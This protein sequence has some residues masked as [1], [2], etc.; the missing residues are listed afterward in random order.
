MTLC[1]D[2]TRFLP[3]RG[4]RGSS[5]QP[6]AEHESDQTPVKLPLDVLQDIFEYLDGDS[7]ALSNC[8]LAGRPLLPIARSSLYRAITLSGDYIRT[9]E[10]LSLTLKAEPTLGTL[11]KSLTISQYTLKHTSAPHLAMHSARLPF[12]RMSELRS[13]TLR[14]VRIQDGH[15]LASIVASLRGLE[16]LTIHYCIG[17]GFGPPPTSASSENQDVK[18]FP[19]L[20]ELSIRE[21]LWGYGHFAETLL[22]RYSAIFE[23]L[24]VL[25]VTM[26]GTPAIVWVPAIRIAGEH[27]RSVSMDMVDRSSR[28]SAANLEPT[29]E[30]EISGYKSDHAYFLEYLLS[31]SSLQTL[32]LKY[33]PNMVWDETESAEF[34]EAICSVLERHPPP[35]PA[36]EH[37]EL[38][39]VDRQGRMV[40]AAQAHLARLAKT[41]L[42]SH[43]YPHFRRLTL[44]VRQQYQQHDEPF[45]FWQELRDPITDKAEEIGKRWRQAFRAFAEAPSV[46]LDVVVQTATS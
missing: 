44:R 23:R 31:C 15:D 20:Q 27:V 1:E 14:R 28:Q 11:V 16:T 43:R 12:D 17:F 22:S 34:L 6:T 7:S 42:D 24:Q 38:G 25:D 26:H 37:L 41:L 39:M 29:L 35:F 5:P 4:F 30:A 10:L 36:L 21:G 8:A 9:A 18:Q 45:A 3:S 40:G 19:A 32:R 33:R 13:L 2:L 46:E